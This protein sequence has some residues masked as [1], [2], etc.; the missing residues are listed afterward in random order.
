MVIKPQT[1]VDFNTAPITPTNIETFI[2][3]LVNGQKLSVI[4]MLDKTRIIAVALLAKYLYGKD[5]GMKDP[6]I[7]GVNNKKEFDALVIFKSYCE[8]NEADE[9]VQSAQ[10]AVTKVGGLVECLKNVWNN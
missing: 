10:I 1:I 3:V 2:D 6:T 4:K 5:I 9:H 7:S 8:C